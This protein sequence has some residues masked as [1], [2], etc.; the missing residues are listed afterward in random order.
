MTLSEELTWRGF[1]NQMT[2]ANI[3]ELDETPRTF[4]WGVDPSADSMTIGNL[5]SAMMARCFIEHGY[6]LILLIGGATGLIGDPDGK[7][8]ERDLKAPEEVQKN[9]EG[10]AEEYKRIFDGKSFDIVNNYNWFKDIGYMSFL[11]DIGKHVSL[12]QM[13]DR[14]FV[15]ARVGEGG[16]GISYAEFSY[17][18]IQGYDFLHLYRER[19]ATLQL[20]GADQ[21]GNSITGVSLIRKLEGGE[22]HVFTTPLVINKTTGVKFGKSE[23]G[24]VW[25]NESKTSVYKFYQFWLNLDDAGVVDY[26]KIY[27]TLPRPDIERLEQEV[28][29]RPEKREAQKTLAYEVTKLVHGVARAEQAQNVTAALFGDTPFSDLLDIE[30]DM[31]ALEIPVT[32]SATLVNALVTTGAAASNGEARRLIASGAVSV[33]GEKAVDDR[34]LPIPGLIKK[35]KNTFVLV[36]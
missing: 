21:W 27:T 4:Y 25:L 11:R 10:I 28:A 18:L 32:S 36:R 16:A 29:Q 33:N 31:L 14:E 7:K 34:E 6:T 12:T 22:A 3:T 20:A 17:A 8:Q 15:Q 35:G 2:F 23:G 5:A 9:V 19:G 26:L 24:A 1:V 30:L 13:L